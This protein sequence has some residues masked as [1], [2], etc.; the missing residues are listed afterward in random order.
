[1]IPT[2]SFSVFLKNNDHEFRSL[3]IALCESLN[4]PGSPEDVVQDLYVKFLGSQ[5]IES[6]NPV[7]RGKKTKMS[8]YLYPVIKNF[9][10]SKIKSNEC[11]FL[12]QK[13]RN[14]EPS[15]DVD[16]VERVLCHNPVSVDYVN[17]LIFNES[18]DGPNGLC[19]DL[20]SFERQLRRT[21]KTDKKYLKKR[22]SDDSNFLEELRTELS[23][24]KKKEVGLD[25][26]EYREISARIIRVQ[27]STGCSL[28]DIFVLLYR[29]YSGKQIA[30]VYGVSDMSVSNVKYKL[31]RALLSYGIKPEKSKK[32]GK[33]HGPAKMPKMPRRPRDRRS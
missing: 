1:M 24:L 26:P 3:V 11:R 6:F 28:V 33:F 29:G 32:R 9:I 2:T 23:Q 14:Y 31:A 30:R 27:S 8:T 5:I 15:D 25:D 12:S 22:K 17:L 16:D 19:V 20:K 10:V 13:L 18:T 4:F 7:Y 21:R